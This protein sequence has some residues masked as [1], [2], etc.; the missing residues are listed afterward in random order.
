MNTRH[1]R[2][3]VRTTKLRIGQ[4]CSLRAVCTKKSGL[5][6]SGHRDA[7]TVERS[8]QKRRGVSRGLLSRCWG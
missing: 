8:A 6:A 5:N 4:K 3:E 1:G 7:F 2:R